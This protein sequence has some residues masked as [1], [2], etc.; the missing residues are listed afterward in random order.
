MFL[1]FHQ[2]DLLEVTLENSLFLTVTPILG[3]NFLVSVKLEASEEEWVNPR[4]IKARIVLAT[5]LMLEI[6]SR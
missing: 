2:P 1:S 3:V 6:Y 4:N 5:Q